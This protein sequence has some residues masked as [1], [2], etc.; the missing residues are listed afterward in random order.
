MEGQK[1]DIMDPGSSSKALWVSAC[2]FLLSN[3]VTNLLPKAPHR[4]VL[5]LERY[6][7]C[8]SVNN[9]QTKVLSK[10]RVS[11]FFFPLRTPLGFLQDQSYERGAV[12]VV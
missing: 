11:C 5:K 6:S 1:Q 10:V 2:S 4:C 8:E 3:V 7:E 9:N 12:G